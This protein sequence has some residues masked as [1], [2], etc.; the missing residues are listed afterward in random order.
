MAPG[1]TTPRGRPRDP[2]LNAAILAATRELLL[3]VGY[4]ALSMEAVAARANV[5]KPTVY[6]RY[7]SK[8]ALVF[9][10]VFGRTMPRPMPGT[11]DLSADLREAYD[12][13]VA[14]FAAPEARAALPGL[15]A[16]L[17]ASPQMAPLVRTR[18]L[19]PEYARVH[20]MLNQAQRR[21]EIRADADLPLVTD[22]FLGPALARAPLPDQ[23]LDRASGARLVELILIGLR[24]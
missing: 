6:G 23:P 16:E 9:D 17:S 4:P 24:P 1:A 2:A 3:E 12:W 22:A 14:E 7:P 8:G 10:A 18:V 11:G 19:E 15:I 21:G 20:E 13:A 5:G